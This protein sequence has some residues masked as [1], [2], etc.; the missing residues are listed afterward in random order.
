MIE[1]RPKTLREFKER[2]EAGE[3]LAK[4]FATQVTAGWYDWFCS[5]GAL[6]GRLKRIWGILKGIENDYVLDN[7]YVWFK[8]NCPC[9]GP[10]YDDVRFEPLDESRR[11]ELYFGVA[12]ADER[13]DH[14]YEV[15]TARNGYDYEAGFDH[16]ADVRK[17]INAWDAR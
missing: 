11:N 10:L 8:N 9:V 1:D 14:R 4:D 17:F 3:F 2:Y 6:A 5:D 15:F 7:Y 16:V 13:N 12:I